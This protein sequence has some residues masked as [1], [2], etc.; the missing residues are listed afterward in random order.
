MFAVLRRRAAPAALLVAAFGLTG[1]AL[2]DDRP[3]TPQGAETLQAFFDRFLPAPPAGG[4]A[5]VTVQ[6]DGQ[7][8]RV[9]A[10]LA[11]ISG[12]LKGAG[13]N[14]T[15]DAAPL[16]YQLFEQTDGKWRV[17]QDAMPKIVTHAKDVTSTLTLDNYHQTIVI[18]PELA[19]WRSGDASADK[20]NLTTEAPNVSQSVD[21][22]PLKG[23]FTTT[24][25]A[26][27]SVSST[28]KD[29]IDDI[30]FK[31]AS[32]DKDGK[33]VSSSGRADKAVFNVG[34]DGLKSR[35]L[36]DLLTLLSVHRADLA[37]HEAEL[38]DVLRPL[39]A[40]GVKFV[41]GGE[42]SK[43]MVASPLGAIALA[44]AKFAVGVT[45]AGANSAVD[46][47]IDAEGLSLPVGLVPP[48]AT[49][50]TPSKIDLVFTVKGIDIA[51]A[52]GAA[53]D[54]LHLGGPGPAISDVDFGQGFGRAARDGSA[55]D[56]ARAVACRRARYRRRPRG[57]TA[58]RRGQ[59]RGLGHDQDAWLRQDDERGQR[60]GAGVGDQGAAGDRNG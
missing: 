26:D 13:A 34:V 59:D 43:V 24:V 15:Y 40:P 18:D 20:G 9:S 44:S 51:A 25:N 42:A 38:K 5:L 56:R 12:A 55:E 8:Y 23:V 49:D 7:S 46:A 28:A 2:A 33:S 3:A 53:I 6:P 30:A 35:K 21:F 57:G 37:S 31:F 58:L 47:A 16:V 17:V 4:P 11:A 1:S 45:N 60:D 48:G 32:T 54:N 22:G 27:G 14:A 19:W 50:L 52:A 10:D 36:F 39:A 29:D 41:E